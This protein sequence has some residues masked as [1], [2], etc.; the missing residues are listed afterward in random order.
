MRVR[1]AVIAAVLC[2]VQGSGWAQSYPARPVRMLVGYPPAS[3][4]DIATRLIAAELSQAHGVQFVV[5]NRPGAAGN[6]VVEQ[7]V[8]AAADG[9]VLGVATASAAVAQAAYAKAPFD[10]VKDL[11][12]VSPLCTVPFVLGIH[13]SLPARSLRELLALAKA[14]PGQLSYATSGMGSSPHVAMEL[15]KLAAGV[16]ILHVPYKGTV[17]AI[18]D[19]I[20]GQISMAMTNTLTILPQMK[21]GRLRAI[22]I[23]T[24]KRSA[25]APE[26]PTIAESGLPGYE[27][28]TWFAVMA[29][30]GTSRAI[31][32]RL[33]AD[34]A[35][36]VQ[37]PD[38]REKLHALGAEPFTST[39]EQLSEF[40]RAEVA[41]VTQVVKA[42]GI[43]LD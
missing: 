27:S 31:V 35:R 4:V 19:T 13:P 42:A 39:P 11:A 23:T 34:I 26:L 38:V 16:D 6:I 1:V 18:A 17:Q 29:P 7:T 22:A 32:T 2:G 5:D 21:A 41:R 43:R 37:R 14:R 40:M 33:N 24:A 8:R 36:A 15:L 25:L 20:S 9:Y 28:G 10:L 3:G 12:A 30:A